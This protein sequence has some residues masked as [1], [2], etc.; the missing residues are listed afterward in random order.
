M[1]NENEM[2]HET[3]GEKTTDNVE[4]ITCDTAGDLLPLYVDEV[5]SPDSVAL[6]EAHLGGCESCTGK[7]NSLRVQTTVK[8]YD[9]AKPMKKFKDRLRRHKILTGVTV[10]LCAAILLVLFLCL[11]QYTY[12]YDQLENDIEVI[13]DSDGH[14]HIVYSGDK[15][16]FSHYEH[17]KR[18]K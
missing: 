16:L 3:N 5:L 12:R 8:D 15:L 4:K 2:I 11:F 7:L 10:G 14:V 6:V 9:S 17:Q 13:S 1:M 18:T